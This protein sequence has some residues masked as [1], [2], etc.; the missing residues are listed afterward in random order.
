MADV[1]NINPNSQAGVSA[2]HLSGAYYPGV[3]QSMLVDA[4]SLIVPWG[5]GATQRIFMSSPAEGGITTVNRQD[6]ASLANAVMS[7]MPSGDI[8]NYNFEG[9]IG[10]QGPPGGPGPPGV[11]GVGIQGVVTGYPGTPGT[12]ITA[13]IPITNGIVFTQDGT[14]VTWSTGNLRYKGV[15]YTIAVEATGDTNRYIYWDLNSANTTFKTTDTLATAIGA[16]KWVMCYNAS[17]VPWVADAHKIIHGGLVQADTI[18]ADKISVTTLAAINADLGNVTAGNVSACTLDVE[19]ADITNLNVTTGK[20]ADN[21]ATVPVSA[22]TAGDIGYPGNQ[23]GAT[24][25]TLEFTTTGEALLIDFTCMID[26]WGE[27]YYILELYRDASMIYDTDTLRHPA[28]SGSIFGGQV[29]FSFVDTPSAGTYDYDVR[30]KTYDVI[31]VSRRSLRVM[32]LK[33]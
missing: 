4:R 3:D 14:K 18:T 8:H 28:P 21:A 26:E 23:A 16:G 24:I 9:L 27:A 13:D 31:D 19:T 5:G 29:S 33:K 12:A 6:A 17:G 7:M 15:D 10:P 32:E 11:P 20:L 30:L 2:P 25:Q 22:Y 1:F